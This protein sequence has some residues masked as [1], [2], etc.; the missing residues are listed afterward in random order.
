[1][2]LN[3]KHN[4]KLPKNLEALTSFRFVA[5][6]L[7]FIFHAGMLA[8]FQLGYLGV[9][10]FFILS[11][12]ILSYNYERKLSNINEFQLKRF[13][14][15][16]ISKIYPI[17][18]LTFL[19]AIP[20]Y[21]FIPLKHEPILYVF[22]AL[23]NVALIHS[24]IPFGNISFNGVSWSLSNE[25]FFYAMFPL[26]LIYSLK[27]IKNGLKT[28]II[29]IS[30]W[31][32]MVFV[33]TFLLS[34]GNISTWFSYYFPVTRL[35][36]FYVG[37]IA[38]LLFI[39]Y[40]SKIEVKFSKF[41]CTMLELLSIVSIIAIVKFSVNIDQNLRYGLIFLP[42]CT[43]LIFIFGIQKGL[44]SS[45]M[46]SKKLCY[47]G[48]ISFSFYMIHNLVL[49]YIFYLWSPNI[50]KSLLMGICLIITIILSSILFHFFEEPM[51]LRIRDY[52]NNKFTKGS[53]K[54]KKAI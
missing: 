41:I 30:L 26:L 3:I 12:F 25:L 22:Q 2:E 9:S 40:S 31:L 44:L 36:E 38:G 23:T 45:F 21:F 20:Y 28:L 42:A 4:D 32:T 8:E 11:G 6:L 1:M 29:V 33:Y 34:N 24:F 46:S 10:F 19:L 37:I 16:R 27:K 48:Q 51:R 18:L 53:Q 47:L 52:Y 49:S 13:Y 39:R 17:H 50:N 35:F 14:I 54:H 5:A 43:F 15:A 7:V